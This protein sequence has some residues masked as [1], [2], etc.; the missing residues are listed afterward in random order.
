MFNKLLGWDIQIISKNPI[1]SISVNE[2]INK[3]KKMEVRRQ[4]NI[5]SK[6]IIDNK[7]V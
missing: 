7:G 6:T 4:K 2:V 5:T 1:N 3:V